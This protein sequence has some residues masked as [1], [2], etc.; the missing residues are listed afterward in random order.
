VIWDANSKQHARLYFATQLLGLHEEM[1]G[2]IFDE[3][4]KEGNYLLDEDAMADL[5][6]EY[7]VD[8]KKFDETL[9]SFGLDSEVRK[10]E[11]L[12]S[13][14]ALPGVP[15]LLVGGTYLINANNQ[16]PTHQ[17]ML[18]VADFLLNKH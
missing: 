12:Q 9:A 18:E 7:G 1:H 11:S 3:I 6:V 17:A 2:R 15:A 16:V 4:H 8:A 5:I 13:G 14:L 10:T